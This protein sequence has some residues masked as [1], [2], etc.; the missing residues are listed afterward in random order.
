MHARVRYGGMVLSKT[1]YYADFVVYAAIVAGLALSASLRL[2]WALRT[3]WLIAFLAGVAA[4]TL[5]EYLL[6]RFVLHRIP[7]FAEMHAVHHAAPRAFVGTP[8]WVSLFILWIVIFV[9]AWRIL[10]L[11]IATGLIAGV[12]LGFLWYGI[13][14]HV[15]HHRR[16][17]FLAVRLTA[18]IHRHLRH[19]YAEAPGNF[20]VSTRLWD[21][22]F[23]TAGPML[24]GHRP[25]IARWPSTATPAGQNPRHTP[26]VPAGAGT[27]QSS[28]R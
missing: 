25:S 1:A 16:P 4:W 3:K 26:T 27:R 24:S 6:H 8:T 15:I 20:G 7:T 9:P 17:R 12:M 13:L 11:H 21:R 19:H 2:D 18:C 23:G 14:H 22:L 28:S 5:L 10:S